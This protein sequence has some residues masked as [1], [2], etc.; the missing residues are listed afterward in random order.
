HRKLREAFAAKRLEGALSKPRILE[1]Y[2]NIV[3][4]GPSIWGVREASAHY[5][6][7]SPAELD[8]FEAVFLSTL[9]A[10]PNAPLS[11][12]NLERALTTARRVLASLHMSG[13]VSF[14]D[15]ARAHARFDA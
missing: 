4:L 12:P 9:P 3:P 7:K 13:L 15:Y 8:V 1:L 11:G 14:D 6:D 10:A 2:L 5:F